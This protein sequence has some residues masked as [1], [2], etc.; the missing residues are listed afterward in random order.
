ML[1]VGITI[2][3]L[4][5]SRVVF[6]AATDSSVESTPLLERVLLLCHNSAIAPGPFKR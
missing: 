4:A 1:V 2:S 6:H 5:T 3:V